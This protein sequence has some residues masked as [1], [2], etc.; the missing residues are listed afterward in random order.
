MIGATYGSFL[1]K[2]RRVRSSASVFSW[3]GA[4]SCDSS[5]CWEGAIIFFSS[6][7]TILWTFFDKKV[8]FP[9]VGIFNDQIKETNIRGKRHM[10]L[11]EKILKGWSIT[12]PQRKFLLTLFTTILALRGKVN[13]RNLSRYSGLSARTYARQ[14]DQPFDFIR[15]N[16]TLIDQVV[17]PGHPRLIAFDPCFLPKAGKHTPELAYFWNGCH[18]RAEK[19]LEVS[20]FS[21]IDLEHNTGYALS[22]QQTPAPVNT[23]D[24]E[25]LIDTYLDHL[26]TVI[27]YLHPEETHLAV[28][29]QFAKKKWLDG[30]EAVGLHT[31]GKLRCDANM[32]FFYTGPLRAHG[33]G[34]Q[35]TYDGKVDWQD[36]SGFDYVTQQDGLELYTQVLNHVSFKRTLRVVVVLDQRDP[37]KRRYALL[38]STDQE[39]DPVTLFFSY[40]ARFQIEFIFRDAKQFTGFAD[41]QTRDAQRLHFHFHAALTTLNI[42]KIEQ[43]QIQAA[44]Q[45]MVY[46]MASVKACYFNELFLQRIFSTFGWDPNRLKKS[47]HYPA[48]REFGR[49][50]A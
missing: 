16:R 8:P 12:K 22:V 9:Q 39:L 45:P 17:P 48:L 44:D 3:E 2:S 1:M 42:A 29:G 25:T 19:G 23:D 41:A 37:K 6:Y 21:L 27:P 24:E 15:L 4:E 18:G 35:K 34:R 40:K 30:V 20:C 14:F 31:I 38:F 10:D 32:R 36:L 5:E 50:A 33:S 43:R 11:A 49:V 13:F 28:D 47:S 7:I 46:S 26:H